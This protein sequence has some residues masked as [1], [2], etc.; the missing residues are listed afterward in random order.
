[1][2]TGPGAMCACSRPVF[3]P[4]TTRRW[5]SSSSSTATSRPRERIPGR[6]SMW[7]RKRP[8]RRPLEPDRLRLRVRGAG[9]RH[10][11][12]AGLRRLTGA[13]L[14][15]AIVAA[16]VSASG[17]VALA[18]QVPQS[19]EQIALSF[20]PVVR[21]AAPAVVNIYTTKEG[22]RSPLEPLFSDPFFDL[23]FEDQRRR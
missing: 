5:R 9:T 18:Q 15:V 23:F 17:E 12:G 6:A 14:A 22:A 19:R 16:C 2:R 4:A 13:M 1:M 3:G 20:A 11:L 21:E 8:S 10:P 7:S